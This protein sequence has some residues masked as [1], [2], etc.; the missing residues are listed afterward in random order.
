MEQKRIL[1]IQDISCLGRCSLTVAH[2]IL[3]L[4]G[5][6]AAILPTAILSTHTGG[7]SD[8]VFHPIGADLCAIGEH[9]A[10]EG[11]HFDAILTGYLGTVEAVRAVQTMARKLLAPLG[12]LIVDP[13]LADLGK[14]YS[15][16]SEADGKAIGDLCSQADIL[17]PNVTEAAMLAGQPWHKVP[18]EEYV[19][20]LMDALK[21]DCVILTGVGFRP[22]ETGVAVLD[23][24]VYSH[25]PQ[26]KLQGNYHGTGDIFA[27]CFTGVLLRGKS[28]EEAARLS[29][30]FTARCI[31]MTPPEAPR[32]N[33][34]HFEKA[35]PWLS[36]RL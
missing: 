27:A 3:S 15:G 25:Y 24:G 12:L 7:F 18:V 21:C 28:W 29:A 20:G 23:A 32:R 19:R 16:L 13:A 36:E 8:P 10:R 31:A 4:C 34:V 22:E 26:K 11:I 17:I 6:E 33:G 14:M 1:T 2:P 9:W 5:H 35:L 30:D